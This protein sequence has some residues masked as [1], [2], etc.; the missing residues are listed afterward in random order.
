MIKRPLKVHITLIYRE[1]GFKDY[2]EYS[3]S[4]FELTDLAEQLEAI[5]ERIQPLYKLLHAY[6]KR[7]LA[8]LYPKRI[9]ERVGP[10][11]AHV[12]GDMWAQQWHNIFED[13]KPY[14]NK[15]LLDVT[16]NMIAR[17]L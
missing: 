8:D 3:R 2:G 10:L 14:K 9:S 15:P 5:F 1:Y 7:K 12:L 6:V 13:I 17:V 11:P 4:N 16:D